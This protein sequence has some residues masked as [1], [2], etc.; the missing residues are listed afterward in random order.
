MRLTTKEM[1]ARRTAQP[2]VVPLAS[3]ATLQT[4]FCGQTLRAG[5]ALR[6]W[7]CCSLLIWNAKHRNSRLAPHAIQGR[8]TYVS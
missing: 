1:D 8:R 5:L 6:A 3:G 7:C 2:M 4:L